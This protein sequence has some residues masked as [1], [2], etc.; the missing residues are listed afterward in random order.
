M[1]ISSLFDKIKSNISTHTETLKNERVLVSFWTNIKN[2]ILA[3]AKR[4]QDKYITKKAFKTAC[5]KASDFLF[6]KSKDTAFILLGLTAI[7]TISSHIAQINGLKKNK[8]E[9]SEYLI[10]QEWQEL[11]LDILL[12]IFP[13]FVLK[14]ALSKKLDSGQWTTRSARKAL[15]DEIAPSIG[16]SRDDLY[17]T[18]HIVSLK[19]TLGEYGAKIIKKIREN[20]TVSPK[21]DKILKKIENNRYV[22]LPDK[23]RRIPLPSLE[24]VTAEFDEKLSTATDATKKFAEKYHNKS[25]HA[26][27]VGQNAGIVVLATIAYT[28]LASAIITPIVKNKLSNRSMQKKLE[29]EKAKANEL[30]EQREFLKNTYREDSDIF[31]SF[32]NIDK[33]L[34]IVETKKQDNLFNNFNTFNQNHSQSGSLRI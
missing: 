29:K 8:R 34:K 33:G 17:S 7:S 28:V 13:P 16:A 30:A 31:G 18:Q 3:P 14:N 9:N 21:V 10:N 11:G 23:L 27:I 25:A 20:H 22:A 26:E 32:A 2:N 1:S 6:D 15:L 5:H 24:R 12:T 19:S 4:V